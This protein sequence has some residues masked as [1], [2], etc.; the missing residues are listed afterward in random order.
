MA[1]SS[2]RIWNNSAATDD[3]LINIGDSTTNVDDAT[4]FFNTNNDDYNNT[5]ITLGNHTRGQIR[6]ARDASWHTR[7]QLRDA[8][9]ASWHTRTQSRDA[10]DASWHTR[11][12]SRDSRD[13]SRNTGE[14]S[15]DTG[16]ELRDDGDKFQYTQRRSPA[17]AGVKYDDARNDS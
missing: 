10:R 7:T 4:L 9:D 15:R 3:V 2:P 1:A 14:E 17:D 8:R 12:Q 16:E 5:K 6:I 13:E 11:T